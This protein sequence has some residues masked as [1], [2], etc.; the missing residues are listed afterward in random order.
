MFTVRTGWAPGGKSHIVSP[1]MTGF[2]VEF[3]ALSCPHWASSDLAITAQGSYPGTGSWHSFCS[4]VPVPLSCYP[5]LVGSPCVFTL[6]ILERGSRKVTDF[7]V[8]SAFSC[9]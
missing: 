6:G 7:S 4:W 9:C 3:L 2:P 8:R 1:P 5:L